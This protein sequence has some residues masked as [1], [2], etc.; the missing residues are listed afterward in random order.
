MVAA[1][2]PETAVADEDVDNEEE[3]TMAEEELEG[4]DEDEGSVI[5]WEKIG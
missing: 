2:V 4:E 5:A 1:I 3:C